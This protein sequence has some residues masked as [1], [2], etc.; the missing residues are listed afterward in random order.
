[1]KICLLALTIFMFVSGFQCKP[2]SQS[3]SENET[4]TCANPLWLQP[5]VDGLR[6]N[7]DIKSEVIQYQYHEHTVYYID[8]CKGCPDSMPVV[9]N[10]TGEAICRFGGIAGFNTC[11]DF[12]ETVANKKVI[13]S[14]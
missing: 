3:N 10:C 1:M 12:A 5:Y 6:S 8:S 7:S 2:T 4:S 14:N 11:P 13:F 9:Y